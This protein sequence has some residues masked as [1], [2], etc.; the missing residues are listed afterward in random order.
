MT[1]LQHR[2]AMVGLAL[3]NT[4][5]GTLAFVVIGILPAIAQDYRISEASAGMVFSIYAGVYAISSPILIGATGRVP[6]KVMLCLSLAL[7]GVATLGSAFAPT[8][9]LLLLSRS[10]AALGGGIYTPVAAAVAYALS[11][12][13]RRGRS[14]AT[15]FFGLQISQAVGVP[16][17]AV[18]SDQFGWPA[19]FLLACGI[20]GVA[21]AILIAALPRKIITPVPSLAKF[22]Q[23]L[24]NPTG[25]MAV[26]V[27]GLHSMAMM[28]PLS[29]I[30]A[31]ALVRGD[32]PGPV[33]ACFGFG[34]LTGGL[35]MGRITQAIGPVRARRRAILAQVVI[36][37]L[38]S[39]PLIGLTAGTALFLTAVFLWAVLATPLMIPQQMLLL[40]R[41]RE[42]G[43]LMLGLNGTAN[44]LG[45]ATGAAIGG[46]IM[47]LAGPFALGLAGAGLA[48]VALGAAAASER[49]Y[50]SADRRKGGG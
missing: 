40:E 46:A 11:A 24:R 16:L 13:E 49:I 28:V 26:S 45:V 8:P 14:L 7:A 3:G 48:L 23:A 10:V 36:L 38:F 19:A 32:A 50:R 5:I 22:A 18:M 9:G 15:V 47:T 42:R 41:D 4:A 35:I 17:G 33:L 27:M 37:P 39:L 6:R 21:L 44:Y 20:G 31:L 2:L 34:G 25:L 29:F 30:A 1:I 12:P 43:E